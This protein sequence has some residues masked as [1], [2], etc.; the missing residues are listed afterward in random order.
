MHPLAP[1]F[2]FSSIAVV[3]A[4]D[5]ASHGSASYRALQELGYVGRYFP[6]NPR[7]EQVHGLRAYP[8]AAALPEAVE[9]AVIVVSRDQVLPAVQACVERG[10]RM[11]V[12]ISA[13]FS[14]ADADGHAL[15]SEL[16]ALARAGD[17]LLVG[18]NCL[19]VASL[20]NACAASTA[21]GLGQARAGSVG[22]VSQ[23]GGLLNEVV[24]YCS[25]R[26]LGFSHLASTGNEA[27]VTLADVLDYLVQDPSTEVILLIVETVRD[28]ELFDRAADRA[29]AAGK[30]IVALKLGVSE[31]GAAAT[32]TH[33]GADSG[34][35]AEHDELFRRKG[36]IRAHDLDELVEMGVLLSGAAPLLRRRRLERA[37]V[38][39]ISGGGKNL[40][41]DAA[42]ASGI[43][44]PELSPASK[45][46][47][48]AC[49]PPYVTASNP[50]DT[51]LA[52]GAPAM[53][54]IYPLALQT[55]ASQPDIDVVISRFTIPPSGGLGSVRKRLDE[56]LAARAAH[57]DGLFVVLS[58]TADRFSDEWARAI[59]EHDVLFLQ[60]YGRGLRALGQL[61]EY[62]RRLHRREVAAV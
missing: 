54:Q 44:L 1:L 57:P 40:I 17:L 52:W 3:G 20:R 58:R 61:A 5:G 43:D 32:L 55:F 19:G 22:V 60:G 14:E 50:L 8:D 21:P 31:K 51:G 47:L 6:V 4:S 36:I 9:A 62:T 25:A 37:G 33:T 56:M 42:A 38:V 11:V 29:L 24:T 16:A 39:E 53:D 35:D 59:E 34:S 13:G 23:S 28:R 7:R 12:V 18:P 15:Q 30:P 41:C 26:R 49:L 48:Q 2:N 27:G 10:V 45:S 46:T